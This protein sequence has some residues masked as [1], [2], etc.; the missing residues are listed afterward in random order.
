MSSKDEIFELL[1]DEPDGVD[2]EQIAG[3]LNLNVDKEKA[4]REKIRRK[5]NA[6]IAR[7]FGKGENKTV[8]SVW[9]KKLGKWVYRHIDSMEKEELQQAMAYV[10]KCKQRNIKQ[11]KA[12]DKKL[13]YIENTLHTKMLFSDKQAEQGKEGTT[14]D[15][16]EPMKKPA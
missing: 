2:W 5:V 7:A 8:Y 3:I 11:G 15:G 9:S 1:K 16:D 10:Q 12:L 14:G 4:V 13:Q 6:W